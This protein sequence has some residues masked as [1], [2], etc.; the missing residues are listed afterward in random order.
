M[1]IT[2]KSIVL[3]ISIIFMS[4]ISFAKEINLGKYL[5][6]HYCACKKCCNKSDGITASGKKAKEGMIAS[7]EF[8]F[9][10]KIKIEDKIYIL[11]D[12]G[13]KSLFGTKTNP[14]KH[15]DIFVNNHEKAR[16]LG[17]KYVNIFKI[18]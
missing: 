8:L 1:I 7:N 6:T 3:G 16:K 2:L 10:T 13:A 18:I 5:I 14:I 9:G 17:R 4:S 12:R 15:I 11:E